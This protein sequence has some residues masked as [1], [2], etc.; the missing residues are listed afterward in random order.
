[1]L[2]ILLERM[3]KIAMENLN[4]AINLQPN[5]NLW[6]YLLVASPAKEVSDRVIEEKEIFYKNYGHKLAIQT[7][8]HMTIANF[9]AK[10]EMEETLARWI[11][12][13]CHLQNSFTVTLNNYSGFP[14]H[15]IYLR[16]QNAEPFKKLVNALKILDGFIQT[17]DCPPLKL[18]T[19]P[20]LTIARQLP[21]YV[22]QTAIKEYAQ[23]TFHE[24]FKVDKL[25]LLKRDAYMKCH[26]INTFMLPPPL[27]LFD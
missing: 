4:G 9:L 20:H 18:I 27:T 15:T 23:K 21:E 16:V 11:Q 22:Y 7:K 1:M 6:E 12:N 13:I 5:Y 10:E 3:L 2:N 19:K 17:N 26:L 24:S 25:V 8:P 14:P